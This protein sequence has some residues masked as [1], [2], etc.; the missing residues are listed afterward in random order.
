MAKQ[1]LNTENR[2]ECCNIQDRKLVESQPQKKNYGKLWD[3]KNKNDHFWKRTPQQLSNKRYL[4]LSLY[5]HLC[6]CAHTH[7]NTH[8][9]IQN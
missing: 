2:N 8:D 5:T 1:D 3:S 7:T 4:I 6:V 9:S